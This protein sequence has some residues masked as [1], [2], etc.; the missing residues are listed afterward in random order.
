MI[1]QKLRMKNVEKDGL[2]KE[3]GRYEKFLVICDA[4]FSIMY[5]EDGNKFFDDEKNGVWLLPDA[6]RYGQDK[7]Y[8]GKVVLYISLKDIKIIEA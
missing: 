4:G 2:P 8:Y 1:K 6:G 7:V 3:A 5:Y